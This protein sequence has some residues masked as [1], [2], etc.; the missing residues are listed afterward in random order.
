M[1][2]LGLI[3]LFALACSGVPG[4]APALWETGGP[5]KLTVGSVADLTTMRRSGATLAGT[6]GT[7]KD[8]WQ[9]KCLSY[10]ALTDGTAEVYYDGLQATSPGWTLTTIGGAGGAGAWLTNVAG[11]VVQFTTSAT[12]NRGYIV[13]QGGSP[14]PINT[15]KGDKWCAAI[16]AAVPST[17]DANSVIRIGIG[18]GAT[19]G[20]VVHFLLSGSLSTTTWY[21]D[22]YNGA[23]YVDAT[24]STTLD[25][26]YHTFLIYNDGTTVGFVYDG[27]S[28]GTVAASGVNSDD[29]TIEVWAQN[30]ATA[31]AQLINLDAWLLVT[32]GAS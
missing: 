23:A 21:S 14:F 18:D 2:R 24:L 17:P 32:V 12:A 19:G 13:T 26:N 3:L 27:V 8:K 22:Y 11:G 6:F 1:K 25:A 20:S 31:A 9:A 16:K 15:Q 28:K 4:G 5:T 30:G 7:W 29:G 10:L